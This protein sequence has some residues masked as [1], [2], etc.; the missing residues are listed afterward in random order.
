MVMFE[1]HHGLGDA[2]RHLVYLKSLVDNMNIYSDFVPVR[3]LT[4][5][6]RLLSYP[7]GIL[8]AI[9]PIFLFPI[10]FT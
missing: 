2:H 1:V 7:V 3:K 9:L 5:T 4:K 8:L 6:V 10:I